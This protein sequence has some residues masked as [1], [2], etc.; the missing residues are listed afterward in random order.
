M[1]EEVLINGLPAQLY[2][3]P[4]GTGHLVW[5]NPFGDLYWISGPL[6][7]QEFIQMAESVIM[8]S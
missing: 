6:T 8:G 5:T 4:D 3:Q 1:A 7:A 2:R